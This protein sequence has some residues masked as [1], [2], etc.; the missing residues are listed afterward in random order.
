M[1]LLEPGDAV[2][3]RSTPPD[4]LFG[5]IVAQMRHGGRFLDELIGGATAP[6]AVNLEAF[7]SQQCAIVGRF[8][9]GCQAFRATVP[10]VID[11]GAC[12]SLLERIGPGDR[13]G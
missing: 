9:P 5:T 8:L 10:R 11:E 7:W 1:C 6:T 3:A 4:E 12:R 13:H 2:T